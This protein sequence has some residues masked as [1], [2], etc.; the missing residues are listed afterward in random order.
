M[1]TVS[2]S[3]HI[4]IRRKL[5]PSIRNP[6]N[7]EIPSKEQRQFCVLGNTILLWVQLTDMGCGIGKK[8]ETEI[9]KFFIKICFF[10]AQLYKE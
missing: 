5:I 1:P 7:A 10:D 6:S 2:A 3:L 8:K 4:L 9:I